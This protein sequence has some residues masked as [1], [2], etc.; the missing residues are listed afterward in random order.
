MSHVDRIQ[1]FHDD[2][3]DNITSCKGKTSKIT[4][5][6]DK[7]RQWLV[8]HQD[9]V[10]PDAAKGQIFTILEKYQRCSTQVYPEITPAVYT[11]YSDF[12]QLPE[13]KLV[14]SKSKQRVLKWLQ[15]MDSDA[16]DANTA[17]SVEAMVARQEN[18]LSTWSV[19]G[20]NE[21]KRCVTLLSTDDAEV[22]KENFE[23]TTQVH[24]ARLLE[25]RPE[26]ATGSQILVELNG[27]NEVVRVFLDEGDADTEAA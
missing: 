23:V 20:I 10:V 21:K 27:C 9:N 18:T 24:F 3:V 16:A 7:F 5:E 22:W 25:L 6:I 4:S 19:E 2:Q 11:L 1:K 26:M 15:Q 14:S 8:K 13:G 17:E 12:L